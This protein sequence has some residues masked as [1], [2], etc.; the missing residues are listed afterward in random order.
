MGHH[1]TVRNPSLP[2]PTL[3]LLVA[4][5]MA[6]FAGGCAR[7]GDPIPRVRIAPQPCQTRWEK[8][9]RLEITLPTQ[10]TKGEKL[11]GLEA[12]RIYYLPLGTAR[13]TAAEILARGEIVLEQRRPDLPSPGKR[14]VMDLATIGRPPGWIAVAAVRVGNVVGAPGEC[15]P[16]LDPGL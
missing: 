7:K 13:P 10:D 6:I 16:W 14:F 8:T 15:L 3:L 1:R 5:P 11:V 2:K 9:R 12:V 4:I